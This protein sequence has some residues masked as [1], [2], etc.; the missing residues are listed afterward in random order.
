MAHAHPR[1]TASMKAFASLLAALFL[2]QLTALPVA[3]TSAL[4]A[5]SAP[6][7]I[8]TTP[9]AS[10]PAPVPTAKH[11]FTIGQDAFL[12]D[13][14]PT[15]I[16]CGEIHFA[17]V[18]REYWRDRLKRCKAMG[19][20]TVCAYL[21]WNFHEWNEGVYDWSG[22]ADAAEFCRIA[23]EEGLW[24]ILRP[25][26]Y[27]CA[28]WEMG[29][30]PWWLLKNT[31]IR[32]RTSDPRFMAAG[33]AWLKEVGRVLGPQQI[34]AGGPIL[35]VQV[36]NEYG[37]YGDDTNYMRALRQATIDAGFNVP[38]FAC[39]PYNTLTKGHIPE[40]FSVVNFGADP[41]GAFK[42]LRQVQPE[43]PLM[44]GEFYPGWFDTWGFPHHRGDT[45]RYLK[46]LEYML[47]NNASFSI[48]MAHGGTSFGLWAGAD[49]PFKPDTSSYDYDAPIGE[50]GGL[51]EKFRLT[52]E[53][54]SRYLQPGET[55]PDPPAPNPVIEIPSFALTETAPLFTNLPE[56]VAD[57]APRTM[58]A[59]NQSRG[60]ILYRTT[61]PAGPATRLSVKEVRD[62]GTVLLDGKIV[63]QL[64]RRFRA[65]GVNLPART[66]PATLDILVEAMGRINFGPEVHDRKGL[67]AP[68]T[69]SE[70]NALKPGGWQIYNFDLSDAS[71]ARLKWTPAS[72]S[73]IAPGTAFWRGSF[74]LTAPADTYFDV[75]KWSKGVLWING[76]CL[77][78]FW[79]IGPTQTMYVPGPWL[80]KGRNDVVVFDLKGPESPVLAGL[81]A[82]VL[83]R[84][85]P[86]LDFQILSSVNQGTL[87]LTDASLVHTGSFPNSTAV[88]TVKF[89]RTAT[90]RQVCLEMLNAHDGSPFAAI[91]E[92]D[93]LDEAG[94]S[95]SH[96]NWTI[97]YVDSEERSAEDGSA[98]N[99]INGQIA[100][101]WHSEWSQKKPPFPHRLIIDLGAATPISGLR[102]TPRTG[103]NV[104]GHFKDYRVYAGDKLVT[105]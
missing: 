45:G 38:L 17:R 71:L 41:A 5:A 51:G 44:C 69:F 27:A 48:Y 96:G 39:N 67:Y 8:A 28:E 55:L 47:K 95:I 70:G 23:Q 1:F 16:R 72:R 15:V 54:M 93:F 49:R 3:A 37:F 68:V 89:A 57:T 94:R 78:R 80:K 82:P 22:Q 7:G 83:D 88:Q 60:C 77:G 36:E 11:T 101:F 97:A 33:T 24:V 100:D 20:N 10:T 85:R 84:L 92:L 75:S 103:N 21:F 31:D 29:G 102:Y 99:A 86:E 73:A 87:H 65:F 35:M 2:A 79:N 13:G 63:G 56:P 26:P 14:K 19:L 64:D 105:P 9:P 42:L 43:G 30:L 90:T 50:A 81:K 62:F 61:I 34:T 53:L 91:A 66:R 32:L 40:L 18:P 25:G 76:H 98:L 104:G 58:E 6:T 46:D 12:L 52:R 74:E 4:P 59:Y